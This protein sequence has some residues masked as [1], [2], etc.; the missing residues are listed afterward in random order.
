MLNINISSAKTIG[1][2]LGLEPIIEIR[3][4]SVYIVR[5]SV[6]EMLLLVCMQLLGAPQQ[7]HVIHCLFSKDLNYLHG[8]NGYL[9]FN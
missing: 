1:A 5:P 7:S 8:V 6:L 2:L 3:G 9:L 4:S